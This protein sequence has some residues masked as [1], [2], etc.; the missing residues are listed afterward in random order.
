VLIELFYDPN[1]ALNMTRSRRIFTFQE[2]A[3]IVKR[4]LIDK[5]RVSDLCDELWLQLTQ[6]YAWQK[7]LFQYGAVTF[8][9]PG[10]PHAN[11]H[12]CGMTGAG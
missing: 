12:P 9:K 3:A 1:E 5:T 6:I 11:L 7:Q 10:S 8:E 2:N 4:H